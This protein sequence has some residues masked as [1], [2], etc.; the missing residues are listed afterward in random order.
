MKISKEKIKL[1]E[2][3]EE[4]L[5][6]DVLT[7]DEKLFVL[8]NWNEALKHANS[9]AGAFFTPRI[10]AQD[11]HFNIFENASVIDL[12]AGIGA[13]AFHAVHWRDCKNVTCIELNP[14]YY[15]VGKKV[16][17]EATWINGSILDYEEF[18]LPHFYQAISNPPFGKIKTDITNK[19]NLNLKYR[20][21]E[22]EFITIEIASRLADHGSF[23]LPQESTPFR[24]S[25]KRG[26]ECDQI[27]SKLQ[28]FLDE[29]KFE[30]ETDFLVDTGFAINDWNG[31]K[32]I[33]EFID[34]DFSEN[35][36]K[37]IL[38][39]NDDQDPGEINLFNYQ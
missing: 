33:C 31:V 22:F 35:H 23:I 1:H 6:K 34:I 38:D 26:G 27:S 28:K 36:T 4:Y 15:R 25:G 19:K 12:C 10:L 37:E 20:G 5:K 17:P 7:Y 9:T 13:L 8:D 21:S 16:V 3:A 14:D 29:T 24:Y 18:N 39:R 32:P 2:Q 11:F 30:M